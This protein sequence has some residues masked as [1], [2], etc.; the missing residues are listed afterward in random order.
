MNAEG[1]K[2]LVLGLPEVAEWPEMAT[3]FDRS[4]DKPRPDWD[5]PGLACRAVGGDISVAVPAAAAIACMQV[6]I[7]L[8]DD[9][10]DHD[11]RGEHLRSGC[12]PAAN[13]A[14]AYQALA[15]R[16]VERMEV[17]EEV[18]VIISATL[19]WLALNTALGQHWD[20]QNLKGEENYWKVVRAKSTPFYG[21]ALH[22][23]AL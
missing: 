11:P 21:A 9:M 16:L 13:L 15:F 14:L 8:V 20:A 4:A 6:G 19:A 7:I 2:A 22:I 5:L 1:I 12:G 10:L 18:R 17:S 23:G 3:L